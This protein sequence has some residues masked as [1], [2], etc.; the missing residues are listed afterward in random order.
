MASRSRC[1]PPEPSGRQNTGASRPRTIRVRSR[2]DKWRFPMRAPIVL[3]ASLTLTLL[4]CASEENPTEP[5]V[6]A[7]PAAAASSLAAAS[8]TWTPKA[9]TP[10]TA[11]FFGFALGVAPNS[12]G[13]SIVY[14]FGGTDGEGGS[15]FAVRAYNA[16]TDTWTA[17]VS[18]VI[19]FHTNGV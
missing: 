7:N 19:G 15:G 16:A 3:S 9:P 6:G 10:Y 18:R 4:A 14:T 17:R 13:Q 2:V 5:D 1:R 12:A 11:E 8:N